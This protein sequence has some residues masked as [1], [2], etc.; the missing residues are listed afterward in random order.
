MI[1]KYWSN[2][3]NYIDN[4]DMIKVNKYEIEKTMNE[5]TEKIGVSYM[6]KC[7]SSDE[8]SNVSSEIFVKYIV[9]KSEDIVSDHIWKVHNKFSNEQNKQLF[10][11]DGKRTLLSVV[12]F[13]NILEDRFEV[14]MFYNPSFMEL[15][16]L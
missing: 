7:N 8:L 3:N 16:E 9:E 10:S 4:I 15:L 13:R 2:G 14:V 6:K 1:I 11:E 12:T 5:I